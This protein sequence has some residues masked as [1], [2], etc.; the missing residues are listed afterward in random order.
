M[1][2]DL[3]KELHD[4]SLDHLEQLKFEKG[5]EF[6]T[7]S[8]ALYCAIVEHSWSFWAL[9]DQRLEAGTGSI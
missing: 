6:Y 9:V 2:H 8:Y 7:T 3:L 1:L 5:D 4:K